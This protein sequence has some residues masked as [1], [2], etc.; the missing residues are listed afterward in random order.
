MRQ[1]C[2]ATSWWTICI[3]SEHLLRHRRWCRALTRRCSTSVLSALTY[4]A[5]LDPNYRADEV[6][7][8]VKK[9]IDWIHSVQR[10]DGSWYGSW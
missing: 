8:C 9:T 1:R 4:F 10:P 6:K 5:K 3:L 2:S 7:R